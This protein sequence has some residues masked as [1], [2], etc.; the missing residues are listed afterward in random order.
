[1]LA[2]LYTS[3][4]EIEPP[5]KK[6]LLKR[7]RLVKKTHAQLEKNNVGFSRLCWSGAPD[8]RQATKSGID[9]ENRK[10]RRKRDQ[11]R[12]RGEGL[13]GGGRRETPSTRSQPAAVPRDLRRVCANR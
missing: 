4:F 1:M 3:T 12:G 7:V 9:R 8:C 13:R 5:N 2:L 10:A 6:H 11:V